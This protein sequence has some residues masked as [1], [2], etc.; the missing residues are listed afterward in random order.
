MKGESL[1]VL[2]GTCLFLNLLGCS[3]DSGGDPKGR[4]ST[5]TLTLTG[6][7]TI[8]PLVSELGKKF[9]QE[10]PGIRI[11]VQTGGSAR[12]LADARQGL[13]DI[14]MVSR[15]LTSEEAE[16]MQVFL[17][18]RDGISIILHQ[19]NPLTQISSSQVVDIYTGEIE[20]WGE[21]IDR[22]A[23]ITVVNKSEG[24]STLTRFLDY[25]DLEAQE[26]VADVVIGDDQ[27]G[28]KTVAGN[29]DAIGYVSIGS[30][31]FSIEQGEVPIQLVALDGVEATDDTVADGTFPLL[32]LLNLVTFG[33][34][35][36]V[37][38]QF[39]EFAQAEENHEIIRQQHFVPPLR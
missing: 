38:R 35:T 1:W 34:P 22:D 36:P 37:A 39:I 32:R 19:D 17:I 33:D 14:G 11:D 27:Q 6:A 31:A 9:E 20:N 18:G 24:R 25:F 7:S 29:P 26:I 8:A 30:A 15:A 28:I 4:S 12:G 21:V 5:E 3:Q 13:A 2:L 23:P 10:N 16:G